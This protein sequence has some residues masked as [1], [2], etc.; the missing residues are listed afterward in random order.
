MNR[1]QFDVVTG[2]FSYTGRYI[3]RRLLDLGRPVRTLTGHPSGDPFGGAV[4]ASPYNF[5]RPDDLA[6]SLDGAG[7]LY[8]TYW[9]RFAKGKL[10]HEVAVRNI[11]TLLRAAERAGVRRVVHVSITNARADSQLPYFR[12]KALAEQAVRASAMSHA[13][14]RPTVIFGKEDLLL[15][16]IAWTLRKFP[17]FP[18]FGR[19]DYGVQPVY[20]DDHAAL[21]VDAGQ[22]EDDYSTDSVGPEVFGYE[23]MVRLI[24]SAVGA[25]HAHSPRGQ[26]ARYA[27][28]GRS[29]PG[30]ARR[31]ADPRRGG[32]PHGEPACLAR[33]GHHPHAPDRLAGRKRRA[34]RQGLRVGT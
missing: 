3:T 13:I 14:I 12:G 20:V 21:M 4:G 32:R 33:R 10:T 18:V 5:D 8:N 15:N 24:G 17:F 34:T 9:I 22:R 30:P 19:G 25:K 1:N 26:A 29:G 27:D 7:T 31:D 28:D 23:E 6:R 16:N 2:A 11:E